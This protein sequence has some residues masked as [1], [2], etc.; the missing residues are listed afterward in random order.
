MKNNII[1]N[2]L[3]L[4]LLMATMSFASCKDDKHEMVYKSLKINS[5][6]LFLVI[7]EQGT[8]EINSGN[9]Y[10]RAQSSDANVATATVSGETVTV[11]TVGYGKATITVT[12]R[13]I[14]E[15]ATF[16]V[17]VQPKSYLTCPDN[18]H[19]HP[20]NLGLPSGTL[21]ACCNVYASSPEDYGGYFAWGETLV[22][23]SY[24]WSGYTLKD[25]K[26]YYI[27]IG[28]DI[29]GTQ[30]DVAHVRWGDF[31]VMPS[32]EQI[33][34]LRMNC[35]YTWTTKNGI[36][37]GQFTGPNGSTIF[38]P[39]AGN[40]WDGMPKW[41]ISLFEDGD[42]G[43]YWSSSNSDGVCGFTFYR[44]G[45]IIYYDDRCKGYQVRPVSR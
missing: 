25:E 10:Y 28:S 27:D 7:G 20:I 42:S 17:T 26:G 44:D 39:A 2:L 37:G 15:T 21:W 5:T 13:I 22:N 6:R 38:L 43:F 30:Y 11:T 16:E 40:R 12:D 35:T 8:V 18:R 41:G 4:L 34:E 31:W 1:Y 45:V 3:L 23:R 14:L 32:R 19:P 36:N 24:S 33:D 29:A 9:G